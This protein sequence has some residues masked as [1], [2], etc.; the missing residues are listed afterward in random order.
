MRFV[1]RLVITLAALAALAFG[2]AALAFVF[3]WNGVPLIL[4]VVAAAQGAARGEAAL[5]GLLGVA[6]A[7]YLLAV[8][9]QRE[10]K[11]DVIRQEGELGDV[12]VSLRAVESLVLQAVS[13]VQGVREVSARLQQQQGAIVV[14]VAVSVTAER[15]VPEVSGDVQSLVAQRVREVVGAEVARVGVQVRHIE[16][17]RRA[18]VE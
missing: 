11:P 4:D 12:Y 13:A 14:D 7:I 8:A 15:P 2:V 1:D 6:V 16:A 5:T 3:G 17:E 18:R 9:W 10:P